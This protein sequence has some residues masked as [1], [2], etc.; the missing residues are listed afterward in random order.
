MLRYVIGRKKYLWVEARRV[1]G[2]RLHRLAKKATDTAALRADDDSALDTIANNIAVACEEDLVALC[3]MDRIRGPAMSSSAPNMTRGQVKK[4]EVINASTPAAKRQKF[5][6]YSPLEQCRIIDDM[7]SDSKKKE[8]LQQVVDR[9][10]SN[11]PS[12][13]EVIKFLLKEGDEETPQQL[14]DSIL[15]RASV[16]VSG[17]I[18]PRTDSFSDASGRNQRNAVRILTALV[19]KCSQLLLPKDGPDGRALL[20][21]GMLE[22]KL[23]REMSLH[24]RKMD[25]ELKY[26]TFQS[27][28]PV[29]A[30]KEAVESLGKKDEDKRIELISLLDAYPKQWV[31]KLLPSI[32]R[33]LMLKV[34]RHAAVAGAGLSDR[35]KKP[36]TKNRRTGGKEQHFKAFMKDHIIVMPDVNRD[37]TGRLVEESI[38]YLTINR[39]QTMES[40]KRDFQIAR[41]AGKYGLSA[42]EKPYSHDHFYNRCMEMNLREIPE[43]QGVCPTCNGNDA[44]WATIFESIDILY[45]ADDRKRKEE[46]AKVEKLK[47]YF[48]CGGV[49]TTQLQRKSSCIHH[50]IQYALSDL[51]DEDFIE[52]CTDH[53]HTHGDTMYEEA[54][55]MFDRLRSRWRDVYRE[56]DFSCAHDGD[57]STAVWI[58]GADALIRDEDDNEYIVKWD[59]LEEISKRRINLL[60]LGDLIDI[61]EDRFRFY[62]DHLYADRNQTHGENHISSHFKAV[63]N[64]DYLMKLRAKKM[65]SDTSEFHLLLSKGSSVHIGCL[66]LKVDDN[67]KQNLIARGK[68]K[69]TD[70][71]NSGD[72]IQTH[73]L[74]FGSNTTQG[75]WETLCTLDC[76]LKRLRKEYPGHLESGVA[77]ISDAGSGYKTKENI[78]GM[79]GKGVALYHNSAAGHGK[80]QKTDGKGASIKAQRDKAMRAG[81]PRDCT[82]PMREV[83]AQRFDGGLPG[84]ISELINI[85]YDERIKMRQWKGLMKY[86]DFEYRD[87]GSIRVWRYWN[88]GPGKAI[89]RK[90]LDSLYEGHEDEAESEGDDKGNEVPWDE[91]PSWALQYQNRRIAKR[92]EGEICLGKITDWADDPLRQLNVEFDEAI[93]EYLDADVPNG[94]TRELHAR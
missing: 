5:M 3:G 65:V 40:Y 24:S 93:V 12:A 35:N 63:K 37:S 53:Q 18:F 58:R 6:S 73:M 21:N 87:D 84:T 66:D 15:D 8:E 34:E 89:S 68:L 17:D 69:P 59:E 4:N 9:I 51:D 57:D 36:A 91:W 79:R 2:E 92:W 60:L 75:G 1:T 80:N 16:Q 70:E 43:E 30:I 85:S 48:R 52:R 11:E 83:Q 25:K 81:K 82:T 67:L 61:L 23:F 47:V 56:T 19:S 13:V 90:F 29:L 38:N 20:I 22:S 26:D 42:D 41:A 77:M 28:P 64:S 32:G 72:T 14:I 78:V 86:L 33:K 50:C 10:A 88:I 55:D 74:V 54:F 27:L 44:N 94:H 39:N 46:R 49:F 71:V 45:A 76:S 62:L 7:A 31:S